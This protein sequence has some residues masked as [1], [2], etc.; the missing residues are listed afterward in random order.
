MDPDNRQQLFELV[1]QV[2]NR[3]VALDKDL[4]VVHESVK[5]HTSEIDLLG[6]VART[7]GIHPT[8]I[9]R[10]LNVT[11][12]AVSQ[13]LTRLLRKQAIEKRADPTNKVAVNVTVTP[14]GQGALE[15]FHRQIEGQWR[16][17]ASYLDELDGRDH[18]AVTGFLTTL[19]NFLNT[20]A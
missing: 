19:R 2:G 12:G 5:F 10:R 15:A 16:Q 17:F 13:T 1:H 9:A 20:L 18:Q 4:V 7:P 14:F 8:E 3:F 11:K 6:V